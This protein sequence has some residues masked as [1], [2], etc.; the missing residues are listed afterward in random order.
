MATL[1]M[2]RISLLTL[3]SLLLSCGKPACEN[4]NT[5]FDQFTP[6]TTE[7]K[8]E[9]LKQLSLQKDKDLSYWFDRYQVKDN[10]EYILVDISGKD[11][12]AKGFLLVTNWSDTMQE[13]RNTKGEG[14]H[15]AKLDGL[16][17]GIKIDEAQTELLLTE[18]GKIVD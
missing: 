9:L 17:I 3:I 12:C 1:R 5:V 18:V 15:G 16:R 2:D 4:K 10:K 6:E 11:L 14:Y 8:N 13:L 7:Y